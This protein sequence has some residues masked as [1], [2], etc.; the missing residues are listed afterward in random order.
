MFERKIGTI[1]SIM[2][3]KQ[4]LYLDHYSRTSVGGS[5]SF[6]LY[7]SSSDDRSFTVLWLGGVR[8]AVAE[9]LS[10]ASGSLVDGVR[11]SHIAGGQKSW[12]A[13]VG[14]SSAE[15]ESLPDLVHVQV[16][17]PAEIEIVAQTID[18]LSTPAE[19]GMYY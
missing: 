18:L 7:F 3:A 10:L 5:E 1:R 19:L 6:E 2:G 4:A 8:Y 12:P 15:T 17:G 9:E 13:F 11:I 14:F 16:V